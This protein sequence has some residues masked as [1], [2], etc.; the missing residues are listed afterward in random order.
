MTH[1][2]LRTNETG[3]P[4]IGKCSK[5]GEENLRPKDALEECPQDDIVSDKQAL[6][7]IIQNR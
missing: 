1:S 5:C 4:F 3:N 7:D 6:I 2:L